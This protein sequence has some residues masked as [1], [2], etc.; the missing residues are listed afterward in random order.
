[1]ERAAAAHIRA[2]A[3]YFADAASIMAEGALEE[4]SATDSER[5][6]L[7]MF[8]AA[9]QTSPEAEYRDWHKRDPIW[10][11]ALVNA[12]RDRERRVVHMLL[13]FIMQEGTDADAA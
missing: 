12:G 3:A 4:L 13:A 8:L 6:N 1:V 10:A 7:T 5:Y 2:E 9:L 11:A